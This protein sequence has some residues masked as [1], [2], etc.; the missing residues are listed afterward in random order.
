APAVR[1]DQGA[2]PAL[3]RLERTRARH[4]HHPGGRDLLAGS[5]PRR[6]ARQDR[7][8]GAPLPAAGDGAGRRASHPLPWERAGERVLAMNW[9]TVFTA[10]LPEHLLL[11]GIVVLLIREIAGGAPRASMWLALVAVYAACSAALGLA[12]DGY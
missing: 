5:L 3:H 1:R 2:A 4:P 6:A 10:M 7:I 8:R 12:L 9:S 11:A